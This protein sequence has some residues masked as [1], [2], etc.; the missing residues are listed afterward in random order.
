[1][2]LSQIVTL[3]LLITPYSQKSKKSLL[4]IVISGHC[5]KAQIITPSLLITPY[6]D[7]KALIMGRFG[8]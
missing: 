1:M 8:N 2:L 6:S 5:K 7:F 4:K 3:A